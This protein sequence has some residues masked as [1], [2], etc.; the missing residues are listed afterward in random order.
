MYFYNCVILFCYLNDG[1]CDFV[2]KIKY[3][4]GNLNKNY[5]NKFLFIQYGFLNN[6]LSKQNI[7][8]FVWI[9]DIPLFSLSKLVMHKE[10][11]KKMAFVF[12]VFGV[13]F[14]YWF[15]NTVQVCPGR[16]KNI[17]QLCDVNFVI[18]GH[19]II[20][21]ILYILLN[22]LVWHIFLDL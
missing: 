18:D 22:L 9:N 17:F 12:L 4:K 1:W 8:C 2:C 3:H 13:F 15:M 16:Y 21:F 6:Q 10:E 5:L 7:N 11:K 14:S 19:K 20:C